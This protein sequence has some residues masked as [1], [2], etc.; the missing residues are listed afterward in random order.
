MAGGHAHEG[1][2]VAVAV[3]QQV[4]LGSGEAQRKRSLLDLICQELLECGRPLGDGTYP[5]ILRQ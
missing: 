5:R 1:L 3:Q 4:L 2:F